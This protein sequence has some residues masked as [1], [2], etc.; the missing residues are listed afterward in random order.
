MCH[1]KGP[2][3]LLVL[4]AVAG[5]GGWGVRL[6]N[7]RL[8]LPHLAHQ[9]CDV[10]GGCANLS[11]GTPRSISLIKGG[12]DFDNVNSADGFCVVQASAQPHVAAARKRRSSVSLCGAGERLC[13]FL[14][15]RT[16]RFQFAVTNHPDYASELGDT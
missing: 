15:A 7:H 5:S 10:A 11:T 12:E 16:G 3:L 13:P 2:Q 9:T 14:R 1:R 6:R 4:S 8:T